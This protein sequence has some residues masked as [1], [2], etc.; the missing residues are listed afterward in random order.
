MYKCTHLQQGLWCS[1]LTRHL[2]TTKTKGNIST[3]WL[4]HTTLTC[5]V[6]IQCSWKNLLLYSSTSRGVIQQFQ[7]GNA[8]SLHHWKQSELGC[9]KGTTSTWQPIDHSQQYL[10]VVYHY[11]A[12]R[13]P[14]SLH[15]QVQMQSCWF[16]CRVR[17][18]CAIITRVG[19]DQE[20]SP[21]ALASRSTH[22]NFSSN[23]LLLTVAT[24]MR[25]LGP[26]IIKIRSETY[27]LMSFNI[28]KMILFVI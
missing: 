15:E 10:C 24:I 28:Y 1:R 17:C 3:W 13:L 9:Y 18:K 25:S 2:L 23:W 19:V 14:Q 8:S 16:Q 7:R 4:S 21:L 22:Q 27:S 5:S 11:L 20:R 26:E 12:L 6:L